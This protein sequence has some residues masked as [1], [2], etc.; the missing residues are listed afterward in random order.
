MTDLASKEEL[1]DQIETFT[2]VIPR[3][4]SYK[5]LYLNIMI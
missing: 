4:N 1:S 5:F 2:G 3:G